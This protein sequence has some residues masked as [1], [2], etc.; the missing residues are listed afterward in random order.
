MNKLFLIFLFLG[1]HIA[2]AD[3]TIDKKY[4]DRIDIGPDKTFDWLEVDCV[5][6]LEHNDIFVKD[7][8][9]YGKIQS[10]KQDENG[11]W[12]IN[13]SHSRW[14]YYQGNTHNEDILACIEISKDGYFIEH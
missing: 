11:Y 9:D 12:I 6:H 10:I 14:I 2:F 7:Y 3:V 13:K 4:S 8:C 5:S 1:C